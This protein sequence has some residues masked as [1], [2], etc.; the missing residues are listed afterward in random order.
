MPIGGP[1]GSGL[2]LMFECLAGVMAGAPV[3]SNILGSGKPPWHQQ[4][5]IVIAIDIEKFSPLDGMVADVDLL[6]TAI[7][8]LPQD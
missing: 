3:L 2:A 4:N 1:K 6:C 8:G 5:Q 7:R